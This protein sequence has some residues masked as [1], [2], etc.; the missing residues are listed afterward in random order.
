M[1]REAASDPHPDSSD[2]RDA[3][4]H[5]ILDA[6]PAAKRR[7]S[8]GD[9]WHDSWKAFWTGAPPEPIPS[10]LGTVE[11]PEPDKIGICCSGG[12]VRSAAFNLG[13]LQALAEKNVFHRARYT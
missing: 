9:R 7:R 11:D 2:P 12:G 13:A 6:A 3:G 10:Y 5:G 1:T 8:G 4:D